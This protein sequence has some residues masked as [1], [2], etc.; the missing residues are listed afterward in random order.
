VHVSVYP[1]ESQ[2]PRAGY[3]IRLTKDTFAKLKAWVGDVDAPHV[4]S[5]WERLMPTA[6]RRSNVATRLRT[7]S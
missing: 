4:L 5:R 7:P 3:T 1:P 2:N 6:L